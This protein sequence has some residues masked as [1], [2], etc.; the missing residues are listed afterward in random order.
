M[1]GVLHRS[2][3]HNTALAALAA[4]AARGERFPNPP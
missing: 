1:D 2:L 4:L 3:P